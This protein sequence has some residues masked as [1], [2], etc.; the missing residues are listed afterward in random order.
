MGA[1]PTNDDDAYS[2]DDDKANVKSPFL[3]LFL[4]VVIM[5]I[6]LGILLQALIQFQEFKNLKEY[7]TRPHT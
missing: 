3:D 5:A 2:D 1:D 7:S 6:E 4:L